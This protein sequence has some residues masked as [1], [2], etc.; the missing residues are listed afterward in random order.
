MQATSGPVGTASSV[1]AW[2]CALVALVA[3]VQKP[4]DDGR[5][6]MVERSN[7]ASPIAS[8]IASSA[9]S[10]AFRT[11]PIA[12]ALSRNGPPLSIPQLHWVRRIVYS[13]SY[14]A[15]R[16]HLRFA[17]QPGY[18]TPLIVYVDIA[19]PYET[20]RGGHVIGERCN[21]WFDPVNFGLTVGTSVLCAGATPQPV[22]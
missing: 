21:V 16:A 11:Y 7:D 14:I 22:L 2:S 15:V 13:R 19:E 9:T 6:R 18:R 17:D 20:D 1:A 8:P 12:E 3:C 4:A 10:A 5:A